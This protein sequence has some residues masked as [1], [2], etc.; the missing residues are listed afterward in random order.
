MDILV[1]D[2]SL[3]T[4][5]AHPIDTLRAASAVPE[6]QAQRLA[7]EHYGVRADVTVLSKALGGG[8]PLAAVLMTADFAAP[9]KPGMHGCT[10]GGSP[11]N[12]I[13]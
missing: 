4:I 7:A 6:A 9:L 10:F 11:V 5:A 3:A 1:P 12:P 8:L 2:S 13:P